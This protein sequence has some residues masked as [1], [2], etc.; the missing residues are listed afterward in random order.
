MKR[1]KVAN[2]LVKLL[3]DWEGSMLDKNC[4]NEILTLLTGP[5]VGML[6]PPR[7]ADQKSSYGYARVYAWENEG[8]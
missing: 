3:K 4:A 7:N 1:S 5:E 8:K 6:P 2:K